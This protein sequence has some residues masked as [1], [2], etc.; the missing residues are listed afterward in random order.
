MMNK[1]LNK[2]KGFVA[3]NYAYTALVGMAVAAMALFMPTLSLAA[4]DANGVLQAIG[5]LGAIVV[6]VIAVVIVIMEAPKI[7]KGEKAVGGTVVKV[8]CLLLFA[9]LILV[10]TNI[11]TLAGVFSGLGSNLVDFSVQEADNIVG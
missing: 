1:L 11:N 4:K 9:G 6:A 8:L 7:A 5:G 3:R 10:L 2:A